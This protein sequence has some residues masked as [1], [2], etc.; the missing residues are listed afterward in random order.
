MNR[1]SLRAFSAGIILSVACLA[2]VRY[3]VP[4]D[5]E[6][7]VTEA[8]ELLTEHGFTVSK[9]ADQNA[10]TGKPENSYAKVQTKQ[11]AQQDQKR[12][13]KQEEIKA[14]VPESQPDA[15]KSESKT[16]NKEDKTKEEAA[17]AGKSARTYTI[18]IESGMTPDDISDIL[19][20]QGIL[21]NGKP[22][23]EYLAENNLHSRIQV[24]EFVVTSNMSVAQ[25]AN[26]IARK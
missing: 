9:K 15:N 19:V 25:L 5:S 7:T 22:F 10:G 23:E 13:V 16:N 18:T 4:S 24:G 20:S 26:T 2:G 11:S 17:E 8:K 21:E 1:S 14:V 12:E 6:P 3:F